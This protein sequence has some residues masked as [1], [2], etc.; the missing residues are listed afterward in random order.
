MIA[1]AISVKMARVRL[2]MFI[3]NFM[4]FFLAVY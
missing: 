1:A 2:E 4:E 3:I